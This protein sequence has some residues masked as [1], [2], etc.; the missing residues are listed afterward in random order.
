MSKKENKEIYVADFETSHENID[1]ID[2]CWV[3]LAGYQRINTTDSGMHVFG[4]INDFVL[5]LCKNE[6]KKVY[7]H[8]L[9]FDGQ[10][11]LSY[12]LAKE[13]V[14]NKNLED[15]KQIDYVVDDL[16]TFYYIA[17][18]FRNNKG[19]IRKV[20]FI[21]SLKLYPYS[22]EK[23]AKQMKMPVN[24][25]D[26]DYN[27]IRYVNHKCTNEEL[28]YFYKD[29]QILKIAIEKAY[30][31]G[32]TKMT[33]GSNA[34]SEF[35]QSLELPFKKGKYVFKRLF[36]E[37]DVEI[38]TFLRKAYKGGYCYCAPKFANKIIP[39]HSY[40]INSMY[41]A[42]LYYKDMPYGT[43]IYFIGKWRN[44]KNYVC[45]QHIQCCFYIKHKKLP[46]VQI[47][48][49]GLFKENEWVSECPYKVDLYLTNID[50]DLFLENY[51]VEDLEYIDG[52]EFKSHAG[53]FKKYIDKWMSI[54]TSTKDEGERLFAKLFLNNIYGKF[55]TSPKHLSSRFILDDGIVKRSEVIEEIL[56]PV[57]LPVA[58]FTTSYSR[59]F[60]IRTAQANYDTFAYCDTDSLH[61]TKESTNIMLDNTKLGTFKYEYFGKAKHIKQKV[62]ITYVE[63]EN[64]FNQWND[65]NKYVVTCAGL[66]KDFINKQ[67]IDINFE[68]FKLGAT[69]PKLKMKRAIGGVYLSLEEHTIK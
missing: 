47:K 3:W 38:D 36:P 42:Q 32:F 45:I 9:K 13:Y 56:P 26:L 58:I 66:N 69:F 18:T 34:L 64:K 62:Y 39:V 5:S 20:T 63:K 43:P 22:I 54:K 2:Y 51:Y 27:K 33:I 37:I 23:L 17:I 49:T 67:N 15:E 24:K 57:Y 35:K 59:D 14:F 6:S 16:G 44:K 4:N 61:L 30:Q 10:F 28:E 21:D 65:V 46:C 53:F 48:K 40:D 41:P 25:G 19:Y 12:F 29:I 68:N 31:Q 50:L 55:G 52:Y 60:L 1:S 8:N 11:L 7:F